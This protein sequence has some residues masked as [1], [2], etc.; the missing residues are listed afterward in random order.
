MFMSSIR[1]WRS[2]LIAAVRMVSSIGRLLLVEEAETLRPLR[3]ALNQ[4][5]SSG[6]YSFISTP[7]PSRAAGSFF[8]QHLPFRYR[9]GISEKGRVRLFR[10]SDPATA[11]SD[12]KT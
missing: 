9:V 1:R 10:P 8:G 7:L 11:A 12:W 5:A 3:A 4:G 2:G 6:L